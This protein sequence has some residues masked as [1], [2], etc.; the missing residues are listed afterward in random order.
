MKRVIMW[1]SNDGQLWPRRADAAHRE[2]ELR[3]AD[4]DAVK[5]FLF[6]FWIGGGDCVKRGRMPA[7]AWRDG[8]LWLYIWSCATGIDAAARRAV[9]R[10]QALIDRTG[11]D[12]KIDY[13]AKIGNTQKTHDL[14][15]LD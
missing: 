8:N 2:R 7:G 4:L 1:K 13:E 5:H 9:K 12:W 3:K 10:C 6:T 14:D 15:K 11:V